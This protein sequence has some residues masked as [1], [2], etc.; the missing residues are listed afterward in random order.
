MLEHT[1]KLLTC[2]FRKRALGELC[3]CRVKDDVDE[4][5]ERVFDMVND[6]DAAVRY[7]V[8]HTICDGS[9]G[10]LEDRVMDCVD[11]LNRDSDKKVRFISLRRLSIHNVVQIRRAAH[12]VMASYRKSGKWNIM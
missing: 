1:H 5:W 2:S 8:L 4:F 11:E 10:H 7:Q 6:P 3:P 9:P 12:K